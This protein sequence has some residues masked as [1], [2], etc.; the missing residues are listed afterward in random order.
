MYKNDMERWIEAA[1]IRAIK[2]A[3]ESALGVIG[4][5]KVFC[6]VNWKVV[7]GTVALSMVFSFLISIK[8]LPEL[9]VKGGEVDGK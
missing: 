6:E 1:S 4:S 5:S 8:G 2:T 7:F 9:D 3:A